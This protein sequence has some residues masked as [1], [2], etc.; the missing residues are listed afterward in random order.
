MNEDTRDKVAA[1]L[2]VFQGVPQLQTGGPVMQ[3]DRFRSLT[4]SWDEYR[5][6]RRQDGACWRGGVV[7]GM[8]REW[9][10]KME[11]CLKTSTKMRSMWD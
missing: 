1:M 4:H 7:C 6:R 2:V 11:A 9:S 3:G 8:K 5:R 10:Q